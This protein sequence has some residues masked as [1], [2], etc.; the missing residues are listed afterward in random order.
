MADRLGDF[1]FREVL[2]LLLSHRRSQLEGT[3]V[4][5]SKHQVIDGLE[6]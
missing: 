2:R 1:E 4:Y 3:N 6:W 5:V